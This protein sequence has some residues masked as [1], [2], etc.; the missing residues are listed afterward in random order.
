MKAAL[1]S[2]LL[3]AASAFAAE[4]AP[5]FT[6][7]DLDG[8]RVRLSD[9]LKRGPVVLDFWATWCKPCIKSFPELEKI[10]QKYK[11]KGLTVVGINEDGP[12]NQKNVKPFV[13]K[14]GVT[15]PILFDRKNEL[16]RKMK[17]QA[18]PTTFLVARDGSIVDMHVGFSSSG[19]KKLDAQIAALLRKAGKK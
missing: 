2:I 6:L 8:K 10:Y 11:D 7:T 5:E 18:L 4:K 9:L 17:V 13:K 15:F 1:L 12:R 19:I 3:L 16:M 14:L